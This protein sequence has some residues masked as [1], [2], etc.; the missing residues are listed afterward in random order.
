MQTANS[1]SLAAANGP[2]LSSGGNF[3]RA[4]L[5]IQGKLFGDWSY[6][7]NYDFA[8]SGAEAPGHIQQT[9]IQYDGLGPFAV[10]VG[11]FSPANGLEDTTGAGDTPFLER[12]APADA[13]RN[14]AGGD[15]RDAIA[16]IYADDRIFGSVAYSGNKIQDAGSFDEQTA[17]IGRLSGL[18]YSNDD[19]KIVIGLGGS[20]VFKVADI[21]AGRN[22][23][24]TIT[25]NA[26][27]EITVDNTAT[28]LVTTG[29]LNAQRVW[30]WGLEGATQWKNLYAQAGYFRYGLDLRGATG[31]YG[32]SGWY[33]EA[34]WILTGESL[35]Y[36]PATGAF[37]NPKPR[38]PFSLNGGGLGAWE[39]AARFS[40]LN[41]ND[42]AGIVGSA[43]PAGGL[44]GGEQKIWTA[45]INW[46]PVSALKFE[47]QYQNIDVN[48][49]GTVPAAGTKAAIN[50][51][52]IG[53]TL[54]VLA[55]RTQVA[56]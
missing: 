49:I 33:S 20:Y 14:I 18:A 37:T 56:F 2:D 38:I 4:W 6:Y 16:L 13:A 22:A 23:A 30:Q 47:L 11:A 34:T 54:N 43:L 31:A 55:L 9:Y 44:R 27:P 19:T 5:G 36:A 21:A 8:G 51:A 10:R 50:N 40:D 25:V 28:K 24:R 32:F 15:G 3:R 12:N 39:L 35:P 17:V 45:G 42:K 29:S 26:G 53:Q 1:L 7:F 48:H 52:Q 46:Y 41:L